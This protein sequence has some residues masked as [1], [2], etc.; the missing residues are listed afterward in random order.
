MDR[1]DGSPRPLGGAVEIATFHGKRSH[2][3]VAVSLDYL[4]SSAGE[5][6]EGQRQDLRIRPGSRAWNQEFVLFEI[7]ERLDLRREPR[8]RQTGVAVHAA[9][10]SELERIEIPF[11]LAKHRLEWQPAPDP[12]DDR[13]LLRRDPVNV[14]FGLEP[15]GTGHVLDDN[16][17]L[18][19]N[20][21]AEG[22]SEQPRVDVIG[23]ARARKDT[24][25]DLAAFVELLRRLGASNARTCHKQ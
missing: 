22:A 1:H 11:I 19:G 2:R 4:E 13:A 9:K 15:A 25:A 7:L 5:T 16:C 14:F 21:V 8:H 10:P 20:V 18:A 3:S 23:R 12:P 6:V 24:N 17:R